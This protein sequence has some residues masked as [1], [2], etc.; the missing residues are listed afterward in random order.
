MQ[1]QR[2][3]GYDQKGAKGGHTEQAR[4]L[5]GRQT[6]H[7]RETGDVSHQASVAEQVL[8][9]FLLNVG[10]LLGTLDEANAVIVPVKPKAL[11]LVDDLIRVDNAIGAIKTGGIDD[12]PRRPWLQR[13]AQSYFSAADEAHRASATSPTDGSQAGLLRQSRRCSRRLGVRRVALALFCSFHVTVDLGL[14]SAREVPRR[15]LEEDE[16]KEHSNELGHSRAPAG[17]GQVLDDAAVACLE[18]QDRGEDRKR[19]TDDGP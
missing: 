19:P 3:D 17:L 5:Q 10:V 12:D 13:T 2:S 8:F 9:A 4:V 14:K 6:S 16:P 7:R 18:K 11:G 1:A 15:D